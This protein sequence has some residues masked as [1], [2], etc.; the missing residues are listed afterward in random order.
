MAQT[1]TQRGSPSS[2]WIHRHFGGNK[3]VLGTSARRKPSIPLICWG[4]RPGF[5]CTFGSGACAFLRVW[6]WDQQQWHPLVLARNVNSW[7][8]S[9]PTESGILE[10]GLAIWVFTGPLG[11]CR[12]PPLGLRVTGLV[13]WPFPMQRGASDL[14]LSGQ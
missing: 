3:E 6:S 9:R 2:L 10:V 1:R 12:C 14:F 11:R 8:H 5:L 4:R 13:L 7:A